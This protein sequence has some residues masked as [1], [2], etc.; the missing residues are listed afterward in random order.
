MISIPPAHLAPESCQAGYGVHVSPRHI[1]LP[2][3]CRR[4]T[5]CCQMPAQLHEQAGFEASVTQGIG[6]PPMTVLLL[7]SALRARCRLKCHKDDGM[8]NCIATLIGPGAC[9]EVRSGSGDGPE[10]PCLAR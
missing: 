9:C 7:A 3:A 1:L 4:G 8:N 6:N 2:N 5:F 10:A